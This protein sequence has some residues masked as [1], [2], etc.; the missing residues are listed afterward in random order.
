M[1]ATDLEMQMIQLY[2][3][4]FIGIDESAETLQWPPE[5]RLVGVQQLSSRTLCR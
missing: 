1:L 5:T 4:G 3:G 2:L